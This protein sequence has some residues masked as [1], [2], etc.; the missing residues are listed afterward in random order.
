[1]GQY[2]NKTPKQAKI[3]KKKEAG[4]SKKQEFKGASPIIKW[5]NVG[6]RPKYL[7]LEVN[8]LAWIKSLR[9]NQKIIKA[10]WDHVDPNLIKWLFKCCGVST[11][12]DG[13]EEDIL[14]NYNWVA[15]PECQNEGVTIILDEQFNSNNQESDEDSN[16]QE[17]DEDLYYDDQISEY[18]FM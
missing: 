3:T 11:A 12:Q 6:A 4:T 8:L 1:M 10:A 14:F 17:S 9:S 18:V 13:S 5:L 16:N 2:K 15:N 7:L